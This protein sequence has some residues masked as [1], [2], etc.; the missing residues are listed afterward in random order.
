[1]ESI[2]SETEGQG[3]PEGSGVSL[4]PG[5]ENRVAQWQQTGGFPYPDLQVSPAPLPQQYTRDELRLM[6]HLSA[7]S[8]DLMVKGTSNLTVWTEKMPR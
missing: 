2:E 3:S 8:N 7:I 1:M 4:T 6:H 5:S